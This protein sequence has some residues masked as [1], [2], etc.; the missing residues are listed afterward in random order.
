MMPPPEVRRTTIIHKDASVEAIVGF[1]A[2]RLTFNNG[3]STLHSMYAQ[4]EWTP[5]TALDAECKARAY[6][7]PFD[8]ED[9]AAAHRENCRCGIY[10][11]RS[12]TQLGFEVWSLPPSIM[13]ETF[14]YVVAGEVYLWGRVHVHERGYRADHAKIACLYPEF[15]PRDYGIVRTRMARNGAAARMGIELAALQYGVPLVQAHNHNS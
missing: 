6:G 12:P 8:Q 3:V 14:G 2:W 4:Q 10:S 15:L 7:R 11:F 5:H 1:R 13:G 9:T